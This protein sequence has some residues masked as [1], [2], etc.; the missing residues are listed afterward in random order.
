MYKCEWCS[1]NF[2]QKTNK[3]RH[4]KKCGNQPKIKLDIRPKP[5]H[6]ETI[7]LNAINDMRCELS[8]LKNKID[9]PRETNV[10]NI[11]KNINVFVGGDAYQSLIDKY[12]KDNAMSMLLND[13]TSALAKNLYFEG[14]APNSYP[15]ACKDNLHFR[16]LN[17]KS[18]V[19]DD[20]GGEK[21][22]TAVI[23]HMRNTMIRAVNEE[24]ENQIGG[25]IKPNITGDTNILQ[26]RLL[27][28]SQRDL[29]PELSEMSYNPNHPFFF[30]GE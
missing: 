1:A 15:I 25:A 10:Y 23:S 11:N 5:T 3:Y 19:I 26:T 4:K 18:E 28:L 9:M 20:L 6:T 27:D 30:D 21:V 22:N 8:S 14:I 2:T 17:D 12:G 16:F 24:I 29:K 7:L 13:T